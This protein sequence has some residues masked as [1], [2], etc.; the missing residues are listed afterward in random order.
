MSKLTVLKVIRTKAEKGYPI[1]ELAY[2][3][4]EGQTKGMRIFGFGPQ[5]DIAA[6]AGNAKE[7]DVLE[8]TFAKNEKGY[9]QFKTLEPTEEKVEQTK[10]TSGTWE[11]SEE[12]ARRQVMI[13]RQSSLSTA[14]ALSQMGE[15][16][17]P[18]EVIEVA[19]Q[20]E[21]YVLS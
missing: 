12:R 16:V 8:A 20:F 3:T 11:T 1:I 4:E 6:T 2:K 14:V 17:S 21:A 10:K 13:V 18:A 9:W 15:V 19:K 5:A 7:G